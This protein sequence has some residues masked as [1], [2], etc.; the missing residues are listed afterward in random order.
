MIDIAKIIER[1]IRDQALSTDTTLAFPC[2][3]M[4]ICL[5]EKVPEMTNGDQFMKFHITTDLGLF[6]PN[7]KGQGG[8][9]T[10]INNF[11]R[12]RTDVC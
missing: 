8:C 12:L 6:K 11:P 3:L 1:E 2:L 5:E 10:S 9:V 7:I 4:Q